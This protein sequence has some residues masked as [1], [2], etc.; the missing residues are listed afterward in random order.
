MS[1]D[2]LQLVLHSLTLSQVDVLLLQETNLC[3]GGPH[4]TLQSLQLPA[5]YVL[6]VPSTNSTSSNR[7]KGVAILVSPKLAGSGLATSGPVVRPVHEAVNASFEL[8]AAQV[9]SVVFVSVYVHANHSPDYALLSQELLAIP[10]FSDPSRNFVVGGDWNHPTRRHQVETEVLFP[11]HLLP[12]HDPASPLPSRG[13]NPLDLL[14]FKGPDVSPSHYRTA[15][16]AVSDHLL[17]LADFCAP[18]A[19]FDTREVSPLVCWDRL[20]HLGADAARSLVH[21]FLQL[22]ADAA[23]SLHPLSTLNTSLLDLASRYLGTKVPHLQTRVSWWTPELTLLRQRIFRAA[24]QRNARH[25][26]TRRLGRRRY[27]VLRREFRSACQR[28]RRQAASDLRTK[29]GQGDLEVAWLASHHRRGKKHPRFLRRTGPDPVAAQQCWAG[30]FSDDHNPRPPP[31]APDP[32]APD[33]WDADSVLAA[34]G[35]TKDRTPGPDGLRALFLCFLTSEVGGDASHIRPVAAAFARCFNA[36]ARATVDPSSKVSTTVLL[37]KPGAPPVSPADYRPIALQPILTK[38]LETLVANKILDQ[39]DSGEVVL[40]DDQG[41]FRA[42][43]SRHHLTFLLRSTQDEYHPR[44]RFRRGRP[45]R[46]L[47]AAF[48][49]FRK[50]FDWVPH[51][52]LILQLQRLG[53]N[54]SLVRLV[55]DLLSDRT[56]TVL[57]RSVDIHRGVPQGSPLSPLL[58]I[59][60]MQSLS[61]TLEPLQVGGAYLPGGVFVRAFLYADD[62]ALVA[63]SPEELFALVRACEE[64]AASADVQLTFNYGKCKLMVLSGPRVSLDQLPVLSLGGHPLEW[65]LQYKY[66]GVVLYA[67]NQGPARAPFDPTALHRSVAPLFPFL[68]TQSTHA[69]HLKSRVQLLRTM[70]EGVV[71]HNA[72]VC[73]FSYRKI[74]AQINR[75]LALAAGCPRGSARATFLRCELGVLPSQLVAER[76]ALYFLWHLCRHSWFRSFLPFFTELPLLHRLTSLVS[77]HGLDLCFLERCSKEEWH[78]AVQAAISR[79]ATRF[80]ARRP[81]DWLPNHHFVRSHRYLKHKDLADLADVALHLRNDRLPSAP[82]PWLSHPCPFCLTPDGLHGFHLLSCLHLPP[83]LDAQR[84]ALSQQ[85][86][87]PFTPFEFAQ[88]VLACDPKLVCSQWLRSSL[89]LGQQVCRVACR[90][91]NPQAR[92]SSGSVSSRGVA[93]TFDAACGASSGDDASVASFVA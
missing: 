17:V 40:S 64:W 87:V 20:R 15:R 45:P 82:Q 10:G 29:V 53:V 16:G 32:S 65:V 43:L 56:T 60:Y 83:E 34:L 67:F 1:P 59:L 35:K 57:G 75:W 89:R 52:P 50:A 39:V 37:P 23:T 70:T 79:S 28:A 7:G 86:A 19:V 12:V 49:D 74:D 54:P 51:S 69:F 90:L 80:F 47:Y 81:V 3:V 8:L 77:T 93:S 21:D 5:D 88:C 92:S 73:D 22:A 26:R 30:V 33:L 25:S 2:R 91:A 42:H 66:L 63:E 55:A 41:G 38:V 13:S 6:S 85:A 11:L 44:G 46:S 76:D 68:S 71:L 62:L 18:P 9:G 14:Y 48:M 36:A 24:R 61:T 31:P 84:F 4:R 58:F 78:S 72:P 27:S